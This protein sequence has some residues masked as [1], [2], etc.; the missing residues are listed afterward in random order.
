MLLAVGIIV[1][2]AVPWL[3]LDRRSLSKPDDSGR[4]HLTDLPPLPSAKSPRHE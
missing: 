1:A 3:L 2:L 4:V